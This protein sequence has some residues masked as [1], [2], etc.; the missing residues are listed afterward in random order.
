MRFILGS[1]SVRRSHILAM[2]GF[3]FEIITAD[4]D[5]T[6]EDG[7]TPVDY[8]MRTAEAKAHA[9]AA[10]VTESGQDNFD[11]TVIL[12]ADTAIE[13]DGEIL[14]KP[15]S[16]SDARNM[17]EAMSAKTH[18][19]HSALCA[20][21][22]DISGDIT[23]TDQR[24]ATAYVDFHK[25]DDRRIEWY[26]NQNDHLDKAGGYALQSVGVVLVESIR[27]NHT[28]VEGLPVTETLAVLQT[29]GITLD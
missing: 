23:H 14:T 27:G 19:V 22:V 20:V 1:Q 28:T 4:L 26:L 15:I 7:E 25:L 21:R 5:E 3:D 29:C 12:C 10:K 13:L 2:L 24:L 11:D 8:V 9:V 17:L 16:D 6:I 18:Q